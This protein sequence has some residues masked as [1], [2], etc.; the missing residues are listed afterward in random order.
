MSNTLR[1]NRVRV[2]LVFENALHWGGLETLSLNLLRQL[3]RMFT[4]EAMAVCR[5]VDTKPQ[6]A[7]EAIFELWNI[8]RP[9]EEPSAPYLHIKKVLATLTFVSSLL[10]FFLRRRREFDI[11]H[12]IGGGA[13]PVILAPFLYLIGKKVIIRISSV[14]GS[15]I[16]G[17]SH[18]IYARL[19]LSGL[20]RRM[21]GFAHLFQASGSLARQRLL[22]EGLPEEKIVEIPNPIDTDTFYPLPGP[23]KLELRE[24]LGLPRDKILLIFTGRLIK[25]KGIFIL[26]E[27]FRD[28]VAQNPQLY[29][30]ILGNGPQRDMLADFLRQN[31]LENKARLTGHL[32]PRNLVRYLKASDIFV[33]PS[34]Y[35][36]LVANSVLEAMAC[37][38]AVITTQVG[39]LKDV[40]VD[41]LNGIFIR[42]DRLELAMAIERLVNDPTERSRLGKNACLTIFERHRN[43]VV[44]PSYIEMYKKCMYLK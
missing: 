39:N 19:R 27:A 31:D 23:E 13:T 17:L 21:C 32:F 41:N 25:T 7:E 20:L 6:E 43:Q 40:L 42:A 10:I 33:F 5:R 37:G 44:I 24:E 28:L 12:F 8:N 14:S 29:L 9:P 26:A 2:C 30:L 11:V 38:L 3:R 22:E 36:E 4:V 18:G 34:F 35:P 15:E 16:G 1:N